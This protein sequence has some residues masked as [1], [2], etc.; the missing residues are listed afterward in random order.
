MTPIYHDNVSQFR[1]IGACRAQ[2]TG[3]VPKTLSRSTTEARP[4]HVQVAALDFWT[5]QG[6]K[7][8]LD[9]LNPGPKWDTKAPQK[10]SKNRT[11]HNVKTKAVS[12]AECD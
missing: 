5:Q 6:Q 11:R 1:H 10:Q 4:K 12:S 9:L 2:R 3:G 7:G 8:Q